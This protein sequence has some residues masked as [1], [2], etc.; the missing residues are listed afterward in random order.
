LALD[1]A[2]RESASRDGELIMEYREI[3]TLKAQVEFILRTRPETR[4]SDTELI[5][6][7]ASKFGHDPIRI[8]TSVERIRRWFN[9]HGMHLPTL[10]E[11]ARQRKMNIDEWRVAMGY[12]TRSGVYRPP[13]EE[14]K[15]KEYRV[16][17]ES[18]RGVF[19]TV[20]DLGSFMVCDCEAYKFS[21]T[22]TCKHI[23]R[24]LEET[25]IRNQYS[26]F[27]QKSNIL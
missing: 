24:I 5:S 16:P 22:K 23:K 3:K 6:I 27:D 12:P 13:S 7:V 11:V 20:R 15:E 21:K 4:N 1:S 26:L 14:K 10:E 18:R 8:A 17:S 19:H 25:R 2:R 9:Q